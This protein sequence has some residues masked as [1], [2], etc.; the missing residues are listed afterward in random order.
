MICL[1]IFFFNYYP[2]RNYNIIALVRHKDYL[3]FIIGKQTN[4]SNFWLS[5]EKPETSNILTEQ[6]KININ[7]E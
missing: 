4:N 1:N 5:L 2:F 6:T 3:K 7:L